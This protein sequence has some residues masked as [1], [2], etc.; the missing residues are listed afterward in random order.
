[1]P[2][3]VF[4]ISNSLFLRVNARLR[5]L[6]G[7]VLRIRFIARIGRTLGA[8]LKEISRLQHLRSMPFVVNSGL[9]VNLEGLLP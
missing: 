5:Y 9:E 1:M 3:I 7:I 8:A 6:R 2:A 4:S